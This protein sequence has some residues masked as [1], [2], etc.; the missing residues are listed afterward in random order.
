MFICED[1]QRISTNPKLIRALEC[2]FFAES[3]LS[4]RDA[5]SAWDGIFTYNMN[6]RF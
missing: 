2:A 4:F 1:V 6:E 3:R 5:T